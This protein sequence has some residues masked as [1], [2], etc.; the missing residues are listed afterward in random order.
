MIWTFFTWVF[1]PLDRNATLMNTNSRK[2]DV[3]FY[4]TISIMYWYSSS[5]IC[6]V[7]EY[8][9]TRYIKQCKNKIHCSL[10]TISPFLTIFSKAD[11]K[12][13]S[14]SYMVCC[15]WSTPASNV[16]LWLA[17]N[18][19]RILGALNGLPWLNTIIWKFDLLK[20]IK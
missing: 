15:K 14:S 2:K 5:Y 1:F 10:R 12:C 17:Q 9:K 18:N 6:I 13:T 8:K 11:F 7:E 19:R 3:F 4:T 20:I 16:L